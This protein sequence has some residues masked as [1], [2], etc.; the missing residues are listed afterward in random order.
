MTNKGTGIQT[1][2]LVTAIKCI[3]CSCNESLGCEPLIGIAPTRSNARIAEEPG[4]SSKYRSDL[5]MILYART[6]KISVFT[7]EIGLT[8]I[9]GPDTGSQLTESANTVDKNEKNCFEATEMCVF[10]PIRS[11][12]ENEKEHAV[13]E[14]VEEGYNH[15]SKE[16]YLEM[17]CR[18]TRM[19]YQQNLQSCSFY[20][21]W[22]WWQLVRVRRWLL[23]E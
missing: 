23:G 10:V 9:I 3:T 19:C 4:A 21:C 6:L 5:P 14:N 16:C 22:K 7:Q 11:S 8:S 13:K 17:E 1:T 12:S 15:F 2:D 18:V 20:E